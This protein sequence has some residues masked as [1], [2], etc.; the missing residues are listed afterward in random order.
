MYRGIFIGSIVITSSLF[1][2]G[3][4]KVESNVDYTNGTNCIQ[5]EDFHSAVAYLEKAVLLAPQDS[6][7]H[8]NL[9]YAYMQLGDL[10]NAWHHSRQAVILDPKNEYATTLYGHLF[11]MITLKGERLKSPLSESELVTILGTPDVQIN[12]EKEG[13][14]VW[15]YGKTAVRLENHTVQGVILDKA[16]IR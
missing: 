6:P 10:K 3:C 8:N 5:K 16:V 2:S 4:Q 13:E 15:I 14:A 11:D 12:G 7:S 9:A 1:T